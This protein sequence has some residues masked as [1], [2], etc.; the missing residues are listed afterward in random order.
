MVALAACSSPAP[1]APSPPR[2]D[3]SCGVTVVNAQTGISVVMWQPADSGKAIYVHAVTADWYGTNV[4]VKVNRSVPWLPD[5]GNVEVD[6]PLPPSLYDNSMAK[7]CT[8][9]SWR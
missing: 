4:T 6:Q 5:N 2:L 9:L 8:V 1:A 7:G 3:A